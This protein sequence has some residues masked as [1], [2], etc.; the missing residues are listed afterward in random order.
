MKK[1]AIITG[2]TGQDGSYL[3]QLL[4]EK[5]Y[6]V[7]G[8]VRSYSHPK[9]DNFKYLGIAD[10]IILEPCDLSDHS[11]V[12]RIIEKY[13]PDEIYNLAAQ[14]SV[15][16]SFSQPI[17][18]IQFN[19]NSVIN[20]LEAIRMVGPEIKMYQ[21]SSSEMFGKVEDLPI[22]EKTVIHPLSPYA[23]SKASAHW[24]TV[25]Y[26]E[27]YGLHAS[28]GILFNHESY[29]R[30]GNYFVKKVLRES[31]KI[32]KGETEKLEVGMIDIKRDFGYAKEYVKAMHLMMGQDA[33]GDYIVCS[34]ESVSLRSI[35]EHV[36]DRLEIPAEK[37]F[38]NPD[39]FRPTEIK[40]NYGDNKKTKEVLGWK[41]DYDFYEVLDI[42][43]E[44]ELGN[45]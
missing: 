24:I 16:L 23:I 18:T 26:R 9:I 41:Y 13:R 4:L 43:L 33:P 1:T 31:I 27:V 45:Y 21:A 36:F 30:S 28:C 5:N 22:H 40:N 8:L 44:E 32:K 10:D 17:S 19:I 42:L 20:I 12:T 37:L 25:N 2:V 29:L 7:I 35:V 3:S 6:R 34:G 39:L 38:V 11:Q 14:S 15:S